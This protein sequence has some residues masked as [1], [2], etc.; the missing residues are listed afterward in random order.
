M[1]AITKCISNV[2]HMQLTG[3]LPFEPSPSDEKPVAPDW[4]P[5]ENK[6]SWE[7]YE[8]ILLLQNAWVSPT[9]VMGTRVSALSPLCLS[10]IVLP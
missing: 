3:V 1:L 10:H 7:D 4:V 8:A 2:M 5:D 9:N 6:E